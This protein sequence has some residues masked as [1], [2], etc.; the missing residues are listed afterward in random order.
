MI[1]TAGCEPRPRAC[2][3]CRESAYCSTL[4]ADRNHY[5]PAV[6]IR[7]KITMI[8]SFDSA[9]FRAFQWLSTVDDLVPLSHSLPLC[10]HL[11]FFYCL[12][13]GYKTTTANQD[14]ICD[15]PR[16]LDMIQND[17]TVDLTLCGIQHPWV[18]DLSEHVWLTL[19]PAQCIGISLCQLLVSR[20]KCL[21]AG[22]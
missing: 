19:S 2:D 11:W 7:L 3:C 22:R 4:T 13:F 16:V 14:S 8:L 1:G 15:I 5:R 21:S 20:H 17:S 18:W 12:H 9:H 6:L 10:Y